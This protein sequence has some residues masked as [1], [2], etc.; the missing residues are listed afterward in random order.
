MTARPRRSRDGEAPRAPFSVERSVRDGVVIIALVGEL[1]LATLDRFTRAT[2]ELSPA[3]R[4]VI[5]MVDLEF[6]DST[7]LHC[8][9]NLDVRAREEGWELTLARPQPAVMRTLRIV[10]MDEQ[11]SIQ[12]APP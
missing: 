8:L 4:V 12:D 11:L 9:M 7:G 3:S 10:A 2:D 5:D 6:I 1:D